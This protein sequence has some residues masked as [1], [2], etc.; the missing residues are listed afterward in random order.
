[1]EDYEVLTGYYLAHS[2]Q[3][4][5]G[6]IQSGYR[7]IPKVPFVAGGE[8]KLENLYL[9]RSF[10]AMRIRANFALQIR[11]ISDGE[12]IKIGITDWR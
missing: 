6:P 12:S 11:N 10:E 8:Y 4:I 2:W 5:N 7:L 3:K 1:M 9:A